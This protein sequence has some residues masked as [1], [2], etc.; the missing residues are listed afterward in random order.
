NL[1]NKHENRELPVVVR[2]KPAVQQVTPDDHF[3][4]LCRLLTD[5]TT[6]WSNLTGQP[7]DWSL[8]TGG[9]TMLAFPVLEVY[10]DEP[11]A[12]GLTPARSETVLSE[13]EPPDIHYYWRVGK[14]RLRRLEGGLFGY[15]YDATDSAKV[16]EHVTTYNSLLHAYLRFRLETSE[17]FQDR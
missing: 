12:A 11:D 8:F 17:V 13:N 5:A 16:R 10:W 3:W 1:M 2:L 7:Q 6:T 9:Y 14:F 15:L 4:R